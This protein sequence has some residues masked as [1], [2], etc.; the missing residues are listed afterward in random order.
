MTQRTKFILIVALILVQVASAGAITRA[1]RKVGFLEF[2]GGYTM[3]QGSHWGLTGASFETSTHVP[4]KGDAT[5]IY[6]DGFNAGI[7]YGQIYDKHWLVSLGI[8]FAR[9]AVKDP[10]LL[11]DGNDL[12]TNSFQEKRTYQRYDLTLR[13]LY[14]PANPV[15]HA[16]TPVVGLS[17]NA[18]LST[19]S[20]PGYQSNSELDFGLNLDFGVDV[21]IWALP[22]S[23]QFVT[24][25]SINSWNFL[26]TKERVSHL[27]IGAGIKY[28][29]GP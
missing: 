23:R 6:K 29:F 21:K 25:S 5:D 19:L 28:F 13:F 27:Q 22:D 26:S 11:T 10:I 2:H 18:G 20:I 14:T 7:A 16:W 17:A 24:L 8:D 4:L 1:A 12:Y 3:P 15:R 9:N